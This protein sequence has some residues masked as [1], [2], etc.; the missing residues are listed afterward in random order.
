MGS[1]KKLLSKKTLPSREVHHSRLFV[2]LAENIH[3]HHREYRTVFGLEEYFEYVD[4]VNRSTFE[5]R[6]YLLNNS[7]Y[8]EGAYPTTIMVGGGRRQQLTY[9]KN[10]PEPNKSKYFNDE[11]SIELQDEFV[12]DEIHIHFRDF[13]FAMNRD[14]FKI[15]AQCVNEAS[16]DLDRYLQEI[17]YERKFHADRVVDDFN[18]KN[19]NKNFDM[20]GVSKISLNKI[21]SKWYSNLREE[22]RPNRSHIKMLV[23]AFKQGEFVPPILVCKSSVTDQFLIV[24]GHHRVYAAIEAGLTDIDTVFL[25]LS[26]AQTEK[27]RQAEVLLKEFDQENGYKYKFFKL[28]ERLLLI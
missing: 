21:Q 13:R 22:F 1:I 26:F 18:S 15:F 16:V 9:L 20:K 4:L 27:L 23:N 14:C 19:I 5:V 17:T 3:I 6:N 12:T 11:M 10:S 25:N 8:V 7:E 2:D 28:P 24:D